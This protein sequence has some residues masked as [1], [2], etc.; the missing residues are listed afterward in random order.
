VATL[1][2]IAGEVTE[3]RIAVA[4]MRVELR[5]A[6]RTLGRHDDQLRDLDRW[7]W[8]W[9]GIAAAA[10]AGAGLVVPPLV[11]RIIP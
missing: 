6:L 5:G 11:S 1:D 3:T 2:D 8:H 4:E 10:G 7:R 9:T